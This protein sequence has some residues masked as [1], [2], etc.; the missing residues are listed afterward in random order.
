MKKIKIDYKSLSPR[1]KEDYNYT[2]VAS[3]LADYGYQCLPTRNDDNGADLIAYH[4]ESGEMTAIQ[5]KAR[6]AFAKK[7]I[8]KNLH[9]AFRD[10][11]EIFIYPH[12]EILNKLI[13]DGD[14]TW[15]AHGVWSSPKLSKKQR[16][17]LEQYKI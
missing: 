15:K 6:L 17:A 7:Y 4:S 1:A 2:K 14:K 9:I 5:L 3:A 12:D 10:D 16:E 8:G 11:N 13:K